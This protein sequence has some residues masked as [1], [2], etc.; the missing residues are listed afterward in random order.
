MRPGA[1]LLLLSATVTAGAAADLPP[2]LIRLAHFKQK[3]RQDLAQVPN[4]TCLET[5]ERFERQTRANGFKPLDTIRLEISNVDGKELLALPGA[6]RFED[7]NLASFITSGTVSNGMFALNAH[8]LFVV[9]TTAFVYH[10][11]ETLDGR[12]AVRYD[13]RIA[14]FLSAYQIH[15]LGASA[16]IATKGSFWFDPISLDLLR[17]DVSGDEMPVDLGLAEFVVRTYYNRQ[18]IGNSGALL[19]QRAELVLTHSSG[20]ASRNVIAFS[21]CR[22][23]GSESTISFDPPPEPAPALP[24]P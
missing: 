12:A 23:Y 4:Y 3:V 10:G 17:L 24:K 7:K 6:H 14:Q 20:E 18:H 13:Y 2:E 5:M 8:N 1:F 15:V 22:E 21:A 11:E 19:P 16:T 9:D